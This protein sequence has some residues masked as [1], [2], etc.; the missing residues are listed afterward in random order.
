[1]Q[2]ALWSEKR[3]DPMLGARFSQLRGQTRQNS[4]EHDASASGRIAAKP[5]KQ[6]LR[7][8]FAMDAPLAKF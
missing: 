2:D 4:S 5:P 3:V 8:D 7:S 1:M 6:M